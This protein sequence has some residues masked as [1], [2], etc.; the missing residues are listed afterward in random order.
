M[1]TS[2]KDKV[3]CPAYQSVY[4]HD[5]QAQ[6]RLFYPFDKDTLPVD[7]SVN[8][9]KT[10]YGIMELEPYKKKVRSLQTV[11]MEYVYPAP[12]SAETEILAYHELDSAQRDSIEAGIMARKYADVFRYNRDMKV[13]MQRI[14]QYQMAPPEEEQ[15]ENELDE[16]AD[17]LRDEPMDEESNEKKPGFFKRLFG[18]NKKKKEEEVILEEDQDPYELDYYQNQEEEESEEEKDPAKKEIG[19]FKTGQLH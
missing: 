7:Y 5:P 10:R 12:D 6:E 17:E 11:E 18:G 9:E 4:L 19:V 14:G 13:Y 16:F 2:C 1:L 3:I 8:V 15:E